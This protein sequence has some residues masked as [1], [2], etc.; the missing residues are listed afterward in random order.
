MTNEAGLQ[1]EGEPTER[2]L[3]AQELLDY[4]RLTKKGKWIINTHDLWYE[5]GLIRQALALMAKEKTNG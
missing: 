2:A 4:G 5:R 3:R 1:F